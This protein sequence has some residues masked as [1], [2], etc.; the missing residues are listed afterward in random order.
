MNGLVEKKD[1]AH[2]DGTH[3]F[4]TGLGQKHVESQHLIEPASLP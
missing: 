2:F 3:Y 4:I 1:L